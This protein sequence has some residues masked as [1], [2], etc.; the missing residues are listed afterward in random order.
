MPDPTPMPEPARPS[1]ST[2]LQVVEGKRDVFKPHQAIAVAPSPG[3]RITL[4]MRKFFNIL[5]H[6]AQHVGDS[7]TYRVSMQ[8]I[9]ADA[10]YDQRNLEVAKAAIRSMTNA[11]VEWGLSNTDDDEV[12]KWGISGLI[13][14]AEF[15]SIDGRIYLEWSY[16]PKFRRRLLAPSRYVQLPLNTFN[17]FR[18]GSAAA[19]YE[20]CMRYLNNVNGLTNKATWE[21]WRPRITGMSD[22]EFKSQGE[23]RFFKRDTLMPAIR[24]INAVTDIEVELLEFKTVRKITHLQFRASKKEQQSLSIELNSPLIDVKVL[25]RMEALGFREASAQKIYSENEVEVLRA[26][27]EFVEHR[28]KKGGVSSA[29]ALF[30]DA[31]KKGYGAKEGEKLAQSMK[32]PPKTKKDPA[33]QAPL[34]GAEEPAKSSLYEAAQAHIDSLSGSKR[35]EL[36]EGFAASIKGLVHEQYLKS[37]LKAKIVRMALLKYVHEHVLP[38][39]GG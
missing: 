13:A 39:Q 9:F 2:A 25:K 6:H 26:T 37:G 23:Y 21:W 18:S 4:L 5:L 10:D 28:V 16:S 17:K 27:L 29:V 38:Q 1:K 34:P 32:P 19:L 11:S 33:R 12:L 31:L 15:M 30:R 35:A 14:D 7:E 24:E 22:T 20:I 3:A 8:E 36:L